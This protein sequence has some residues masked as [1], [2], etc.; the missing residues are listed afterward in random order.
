MKRDNLYS[1]TEQRFYHSS[2][3]A[4]AVSDI[5]SI[6]LGSAPNAMYAENLAIMNLNNSE[7]SAGNKIK[8]D[9]DPFVNRC[10]SLYSFYPYLFASVISLLASSFGFL[11]NLLT[12]IPSPVL[13]GMEPFI[14]GLISAP[15]IQ[16]LVDQKVNY[17]KISNQIITA[18]V[19]LAGV[20]NISMN[21]QILELKGMS[22]GLTIVRTSC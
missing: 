16:M 10:Y 1:Y 15:G 2:L 17:K 19:L 12:A 9:H 8:H 5:L 7:L 22:L 11:Q 13:G 6:L 21:F 4:H 3:K 18:S 20:S 14:F